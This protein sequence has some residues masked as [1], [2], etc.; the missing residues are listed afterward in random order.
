[1]VAPVSDGDLSATERRVWARMPEGAREALDAMPA[2]DLQTLLLG[3]ARSR[4][5][6]MHPADLMRRWRDD[7]FVRPSPCDP[8][9]LA[10][11]EADMWRLLPAEVQAVELSPVVPLGTCAALAP[12]SQNRMVT[13]MRL[14]EVLSDSTNALAIEAAH[15]RLRRRD[16]EAV[17]LAASHRLLR[18]QRFRAGFYPHFRLFALVS[19]A[20]D[21]GSGATEARLLALHLGYWR[22]VLGTV[23]PEAGPR[24][25]YTV[26][27]SALLRERMR[28]TVLPILRR[29]GETGPAVPVEEEPQRE[30]GRGYYTSVA[31][32]FTVGSGV[33]SVEVGDGG[34]LRWTARLM[35]DAKERCLVSCLSTERLAAILDARGGT[36]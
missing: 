23:V 7:R 4:A 24:L 34:L 28:D 31:L 29:S 20:R 10:A 19:S 2:T 9:T 32:R 27:D 22:R 26:F 25:W 21:T 35:N 13:T 1:M 17:H 30:R 16:R 18:A 36:G 6:R 5:A 8:R 14:G 12:L 33:R 11:L 15:R 3:V